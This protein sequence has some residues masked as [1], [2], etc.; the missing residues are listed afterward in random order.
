MHD[1]E[2]RDAK[3]K[4][5]EEEVTNFG[6]NLVPGDHVSCQWADGMVYEAVIVEQQSDL[7]RYP[8]DVFT[9]SCLVDFK[10]GETYSVPWFKME[11]LTGSH[12][13]LD[14]DDLNNSV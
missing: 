5:K 9:F 2:K 8:T 13:L 10:T 14:A 3:R 6:S 7:Q 1:P 12:S 11:R 4:A